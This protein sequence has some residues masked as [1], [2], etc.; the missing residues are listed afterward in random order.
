M[1]IICVGEGLEVRQAGEHVRVLLAQVDG[2]LAGI[3]A[4]QAGLAW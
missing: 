4:E 3:T 2:A 1:P